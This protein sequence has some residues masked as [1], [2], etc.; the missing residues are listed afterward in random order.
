MSKTPEVT[1]TDVTIP[2]AAAAPP[3][4]PARRVVEVDAE[5]FEAIQRRLL[6][7]EKANT[8]TATGEVVAMTC[9]SCGRDV[10]GE[11][12]QRCPTHPTEFVN[13]QGFA[14]DVERGGKRPAI[15]RQTR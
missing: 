14:V 4:D 13:H 6:A 5:E 8:A 2:P 3:R 10:S 12:N 1:K 15:L 7:V 9:N 11:K